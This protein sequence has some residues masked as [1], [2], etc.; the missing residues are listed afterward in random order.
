MSRTKDVDA[1]WLIAVA[2]KGVE[3]RAIAGALELSINTVRSTDWL[4]SRAKLGANNHAQ[5][6]A[7]LLRDDGQP[8]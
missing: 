1:Q 8:R 5:A 6:V 7:L 2:C 4:R 3:D